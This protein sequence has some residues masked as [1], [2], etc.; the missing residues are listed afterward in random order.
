VRQRQRNASATRY[1]GS[2]GAALT[3][4]TFL[5]QTILRFSGAINRKKRNLL[6]PAQTIPT[7][8]WSDHAGSKPRPSEKNEQLREWLAESD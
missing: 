4:S 3:I 8:R 1:V 6:Y 2:F 5:S 7:S